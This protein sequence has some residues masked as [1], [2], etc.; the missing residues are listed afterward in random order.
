VRNGGD[1]GLLLAA[2]PEPEPAAD[3][4]HERRLGL[5]RLT[6]PPEPHYLACKDASPE[7]LEAYKEAKRF[8]QQRNAEA[9]QARADKH[10]KI[11]AKGFEGKGKDQLGM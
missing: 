5:P 1:G 3:P 10:R 6:A 4:A 8:V 11:K 2:V 7:D 9:V